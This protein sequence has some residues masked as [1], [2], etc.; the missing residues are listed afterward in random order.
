MPDIVEMSEGMNG[1]I[2][3]YRWAFG[4]QAE[5]LDE[6]KANFAPGQDRFAYLVGKDAYTWDSDSA[7]FLL[8]GQWQGPIGPDGLGVPVGGATGQ[9]LIKASD[10]DHD[11]VW[12]TL[13]L[14]SKADKAIVESLASTVLGHTTQI[15]AKV[16]ASTFTSAIALK[17]DKG[18]LNDLAAEVADK[19][20]QTIVTSIG[21][22]VA[23]LENAV[24]EAVYS[25]TINT[26]YGIY[27]TLYKDKNGTVTF[28]MVRPGGASPKGGNITSTIF[29]A[30]YT[31]PAG[32]RPQSAFYAPFWSR[33]GASPIVNRV[34]ISTTGV[35][36][37]EVAATTMLGF[38]FCVTFP[39]V[40]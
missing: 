21:D 19:A 34:Y 18:A 38:I 32:Y 16:D 22:R 4:G 29:N 2:I 24:N 23:S 33:D 26:A 40:Y 8:I 12:I 31:L 14:S 25:F 10:A 3:M 20:N 36:T 7:D 5:T 9:V 39:T 35:L 13:D 37:M 6:L 27:G 28:T 17:A 15:A 30:L 1:N 11:T